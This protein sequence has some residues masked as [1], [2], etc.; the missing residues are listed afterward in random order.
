MYK[1]LLLHDC[2]RRLTCADVS[3]LC[4]TTKQYLIQR[5]S[6]KKK[7][8]TAPLPPIAPCALLS[9]PQKI[10]IAEQHSVIKTHVYTRVPFMYLDL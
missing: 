9:P 8:L 10:L 4:S 6:N 1:L 7:L 2:E 3:Q 5:N